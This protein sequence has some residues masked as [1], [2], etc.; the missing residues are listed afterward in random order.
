MKYAGVTA[1]LAG[2]RPAVVGLIA[3]TAGILLLNNLIGIQLFTQVTAPDGTG[4][5]IFICLVT[6]ALVYKKMKGRSLSPI[7]LLLIS[8]GIG[9]LE[10]V[11]KTL[12][13]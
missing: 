2:V 3:A 10:G 6:I 12:A 4:I 1:F 8:A 7:L 5:A 9:I 13:A 11:V